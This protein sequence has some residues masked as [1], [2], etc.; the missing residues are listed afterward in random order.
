MSRSRIVGGSYTKVSKG[1]HQMFSEESIVSSAGKKVQ[2]K[3][4]NEGVSHGTPQ[5]APKP[6]MLLTYM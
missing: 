5:T 1:N 3:G 6:R 2:Q 4:A